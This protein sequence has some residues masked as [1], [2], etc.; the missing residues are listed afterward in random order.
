[1]RRSITAAS[2]ISGIEE[3][4]EQAVEKVLKDVPEGAA[5]G[6]GDLLKGDKK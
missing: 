5:K 2:G 1:V 6:L 4:G 3:L